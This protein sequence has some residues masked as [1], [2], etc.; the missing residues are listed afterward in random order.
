MS[1][2]MSAGLSPEQQQ[3]FD[4]DIAFVLKNAVAHHHRGELANAQALYEAVL[5]AKPDQVDACYNLAVL[6]VQCGD[7]N[8]ALPHFETALGIDPNNG[9]HWVS[10]VNALIE[11]G[12]ISAAWTVLGMCQQ[13][14]F[15][16]PA[17]DGLIQ[18]LALSAEGNAATVFTAAANAASAAPAR[19]QA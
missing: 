3:Q 10:Y 17:V 14:G 12:Q 1:D 18:R 6:K 19:A 13:R 2:T 9:Q 15:K 4:A 16:G 5:G 8:G 11:A 7:A